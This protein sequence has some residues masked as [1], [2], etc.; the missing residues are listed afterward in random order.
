MGMLQ[1]ALPTG[2]IVPAQPIGAKVPPAGPGWL[3]EIK[4]DGFRLMGW[5]NS[6]R[7]RLLTRNG[8]D[9]TD[10]FPLVAEA[11]GKLAARSCLIDG[12]IAVCNGMGLS[13]F[14]ML[15]R[16]PQIKRNAVLFS[17]DLLE[18]D[19]Q[20]LRLEPIECRKAELEKLLHGAPAPLHWLEHLEVEGPIMFELVCT[21]GAEGIVS[22]RK[23]SRYVSGRCD[24]WRKVKNPAAPAVRREAEEDW[25]KR[26][27]R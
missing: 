10:R 9:F 15:R 27:W 23:G 17:F 3:H 8:T 6:D 2:F 22:K 16:G 24:A 13:V 5:R 20:D 18:L 21:L 7:V 26:R 12:E 11:I 25:G 1:R 19:G 14:D 4:H